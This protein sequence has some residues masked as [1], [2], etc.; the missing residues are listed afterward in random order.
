M[1]RFQTLS[2]FLLALCALGAAAGSN[3]LQEVPHG[4]DP[5]HI[6]AHL[7]FLADDL[8]E[9]RAPG[10]RGERLA[11]NYLA[12]Q[13][14]QS[15]VEPA[16]GSYF[17]PVPLIAWRPDPRRTSATVS[18]KAT[19]MTP[20]ALR[21]P[22]DVVLWVD[23]ADSAS[24]TGELVFVGYGVRAPEYQWDDYKKRD[25][26]GRIV[27]VLV[28]DPPVPPGQPL[29][30]EGPAVTYYGRWTYKLEEAARQGAAAVLLVHSTDGA[31]YAWRVVEA[32]WTRERLALAANADSATSPL[33]L[34]GWVTTDAAR[35]TF[36]LAN[37]DFTELFVRAARRDFQP[38]YTGI[39]GRLNAVGRTRRVDATNVIGVVPGRSPARRGE[40]VIYT[41]HYDHLGIGLPVNGDSI[42]N[43]AYDNASGVAVLLEIAEAFAALPTPPE[44]TVI[45]LFTTAEEAGL[46]GAQHYIRQPLLP[47]T[48]TVAALNIDG[49]NVWG[50]TND[51]GAVGLERSTLGGVFQLHAG[52]LGLQ[53]Q[54]ERAPEKGFFYRSDH[55]AFA[56]AGVP[57][58]SFDHGLL[59]RDRPPGWGEELLSRY[60][61]DRYHQ[62]DDEFDPAFD[63]AGAAQQ[64]QLAFL[65]GLDVANTPLPPRWHR[66]PGVPRA[67]PRAR[68][69]RR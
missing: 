1:R 60:E 42:Y 10:T 25:V 20:S 33:R 52:A 12:S 36:A 44:R 4:I 37:L 30:F 66:D 32:S 54:A 40:A 46:L 59:Y 45:F 31:G 35:R 24:V 41:A 49:A 43:G 16:R 53:V 56:R 3:P 2:P 14:A 19:N 39:T 15:R 51:A 7:V 29:N 21:Y 48:R 62:P 26:R 27:V 6:R 18:T 55:F 17:Q 11:A 23:A 13:L 38:V 34:Q 22:S 61:A 47:I 67:I 8:L 68:E 28:G 64:G 9:G 65:V 57:A 63:L 50:E 58:L 5:T 69:T